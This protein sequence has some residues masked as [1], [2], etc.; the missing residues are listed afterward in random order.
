MRLVAELPGV[1]PSPVAMVQAMAADS[2]SRVVELRH[3]LCAQVSR[4]P[5]PSGEDEE[6]GAQPVLLQDRQRM[7][8]IRGVAVIEGEA[9]PLGRGRRGDR[10][11][12]LDRDPDRRS[13]AGIDGGGSPSPWKVMISSLRERMAHPRRR[14]I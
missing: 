14:M 8:D 4:L 7:L 11:E 5:E 9:Q 6:P 2:H 10:I 13:S 1:D 3:V 12:P